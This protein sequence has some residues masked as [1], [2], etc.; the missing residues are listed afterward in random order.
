M[1]KNFVFS[2]TPSEFTV[3]NNKPN[4]AFA[5]H[6]P[7]PAFT[8]E[9]NEAF[10][11]HKPTPAFTGNR[12]YKSGQK[13]GQQTPSYIKWSKENQNKPDFSKPIVVGG[14]V[15]TVKGF[16][17]V[18]KVKD[19]RVNAF[20][21]KEKLN[22]EMSHGVMRPKPSSTQSFN[23]NQQ[24][25][26]AFALYPFV[27]GK[28]GKFVLTWDGGNAEINLTGDWK[29][30]DYAMIMSAVNITS[31]VSYFDYEKNELSGRTDWTITIREFKNVKFKPTYG[32]QIYADNTTGT[33]IIDPIFKHY[34]SQ[35]TK[36]GQNTAQVLKKKMEKYPDGLTPKQ[37]QKLCDAHALHIIIHHPITGENILDVKTNHKCQKVFKYVNTRNNHAEGWSYSKFFDET[38]PDIVE[39]ATEKKMMEIFNKQQGEFL[40][41]S[42]Q[43]IQGKQKISYINTPKEHYVLFNPIKEITDEFYKKY[44]ELNN[45]LKCDPNQTDDVNHFIN[46]ATR[47]NGIHD[48]NVYNGTDQIYEHDIN[49][50]YATF[51]ECDYY[52]HYQ[53]PC[54]PTDFRWVKGQDIDTIINKTGWTQIYDIQGKGNAFEL[55]H[56]EEYGI[57][58]NVELK[59][60]KDLG[61]TFKCRVSA[62]SNFTHD[63]RF[64]DDMLT[65]IDHPDYRKLKPYALEAGKMLGFIK[66]KKVYY[67]YDENPDQE[68]INNMAY[69]DENMKQVWNDEDQKYMIIEQAKNSL[70][71]RN[72]IGSH[73]TA[74][75]RCR[76]YKQI[77]NIDRDDIWFVRSDAIKMKGDYELPDG[78]KCVKDDIKLHEYNTN[79]DDDKFTAFVNT[80]EI[81]MDWDC[82]KYKELDD[83][84]IYSGPGGSGKTHSFI[85]DKG[86]VFKA[87]AFPTNELKEDFDFVNKFTH[88]GVAEIQ[89]G[90]HPKTKEPLFSCTRNFDRINCGNLFIDEI[91]MRTSPELKSLLQ[92]E[93]KRLLF[94]GDWD[95][96]TG[97]V[98]QL[99]P[100]KGEFDYKQLKDLQVVNFTKNYRSKDPK[101]T[102][103]LEAMRSVMKN[104]Y[105]NNCLADM[106]RS[107]GQALKNRTISEEFMFANYKI[108]DLAI[109]SLNKTQQRFN[110]V[111]DTENNLIKKW[112]ITE[113]TDKYPRGKFVRGDDINTINKELAYATTVHAVQGKTFTNKLYFDLGNI[114]EWG[115][116][117]TAVSRLTTL[118]DLYLI[119]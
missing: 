106:N 81:Q 54:T 92:I 20:R 115:M 71:H 100:T 112:K 84:V 103:V 105:G 32:G 14:K 61:T 97:M 26:F 94:A 39:V 17:D 113:K 59:C 118:D 104:N 47:V 67:K 87:I 11:L 82:G 76:M 56:L 50:A 16:K 114:F 2:K 109:C 23:Y 34:N 36:T 43:L 55:A 98:Y 33:C 40:Y 30:H 85:H 31:G 65:E 41:K 15:A 110:K 12:T 13:M 53:F 9:L 48:F 83:A 7:T 1:K 102:K 86:L 88:H 45:Y 70:S 44:P 75:V 19:N 29:L 18:D 69:Y 80:K 25:D 116:F 21:V 46:K 58:C 3:G 79:G 107:F 99:K 27:K 37:I 4:D 52:E 22:V 6:K 117:Y 77:E 74:Y 119:D 90:I 95:I 8:G 49:K 38:N 68:W 108:D 66:T 63:F 51:Y 10:A 72:H 28:K 64:D 78:F 24:D 5:L 89:V 91:T 111:F 73:I 57:Y 93:Q 42:S 60:L 101:L 96:D 35:T 62:W